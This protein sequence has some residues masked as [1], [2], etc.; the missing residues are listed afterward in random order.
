V[1]MKANDLVVSM[2]YLE[3]RVHPDHGPA[4]WIEFCA[5][6]IGLGFRVILYEARE[7]VS[8]YITVVDPT[9]SRRRY[10]VRFSNHPP[11][12]SRFE[13]SDCDFFVGKTPSYTT[14]SRQAIEATRRFFGL[15]RDDTIRM[16]WGF[17]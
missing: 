13:S 11:H 14:N 4:K 8:K 12:R 16:P 6:M 9:D 7:T 17:E 2:E 10:K 15:E 1:D 3:S 5:E